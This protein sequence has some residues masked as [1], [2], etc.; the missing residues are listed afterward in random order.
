[1]AQFDICLH[2]G[3][4]TELIAM[5]S[6]ENLFTKLV[7]VDLPA[8]NLY[9]TAEEFAQHVQA[10]KRLIREQDSYRFYPLPESPFENVVLSVCNE[11][12]LV[13]KADLPIIAFLFENTVMKQSFSKYLNTL[14]QTIMPDA[15]QKETAQARLAKYT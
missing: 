2:S 1:M 8:A 13:S 12:S 3:G 11:Q 15:Y 5:P 14:G 4:V 10:I 9:C 6:D 7:N